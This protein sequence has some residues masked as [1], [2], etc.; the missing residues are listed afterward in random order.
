MQK[1]LYLTA[2]ALMAAAAPCSHAQQSRNRPSS[3]SQGA[4]STRGKPPSPEE[5]REVADTSQGTVTVG[6]QTIPYTAIAGTLVLDQEDLNEDVD[7]RN[8]PTASIFYVAYFRKGND[9]EQRPITFLYNGGP[10]SAS[11]WLHMGSFAPKRVVVNDSA[12]THAAPYQLV[13]NEYSLLDASDLV[14]I[15]APGTG[16]SRIRGK[17]ANKFFY[18]VDQDGRAFAAFITKFLSHYGRWN[19]PKYLFG[20]SYGTTRSAVLANLLGNEYNVDLNGV[21]LLSQILS[22]TNS[23]DNP[24]GNPGV[25]QAYALALPTYAA[26]AWYHGKL[27]NKPAQL[28]PFLDEVEKFALGDYMHA[29]M[30]GADIPQAEKQ[31]VAQK[32]HQY[33]G[34]PVDYLMKADLRVTGGEF[35]HELLADNEMSTGRLDTRYRGPSMDPLGQSSDYDP[36]SAAI[37]SAYI[38]TFND[39]VR[40]T[41]GFGKDRVYHPSGNVRPWDMSHQA[42]GQR[43]ASRGATN[44]MPDLAAAMKQNPTLQVMLNAGY[45]DL[46]TPYFEGVYEMK[47]LPIPDEL[48][49]NIHYAFYESGHM[50]YVRVPVLKEL[51]D[52]VAKFIRDTD[53]LQ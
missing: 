8:A 44:V 7:D 42:P 19:S 51:H 38:S 41:L 49:K 52:N 3:S 31:A 46:A 26:T 21:I 33:T 14:F 24:S 15:D 50:V 12:H 53:N 6:G 39:Y 10:G 13:S 29:L 22:F 5:F 23:V 9:G 4:D 36:Q 45:Y 35:E 28:R 30:Q 1:L 27:P 2:A 11:M 20:E 34:L 40:K 32:L 16:F 17:D 43:R 48:Q 37:S 25:D 47:H 18:G